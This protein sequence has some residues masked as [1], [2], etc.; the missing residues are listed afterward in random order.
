MK[1]YST[2]K[3]NAD[4]CDI[5]LFLKNCIAQ[6]IEVSPEEI[7]VEFGISN[8]QAREALKLF[9]RGVIKHP[10]DPHA[11]DKLLDEQI[12]QWDLKYPDQP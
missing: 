4:T 7:A 12:Y 11:S 9:K 6:G 5:D 8:S 3:R 2:K 10:E 1:K